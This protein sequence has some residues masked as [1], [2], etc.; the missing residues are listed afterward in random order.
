M[1]ELKHNGFSDAEKTRSAAHDKLRDVMGPR[2]GRP[3]KEKLAN[4]FTLRCPPCG[5]MM[6]LLDAQGVAHDF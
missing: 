2:R 3:M 1:I 5:S 6:G 4:A